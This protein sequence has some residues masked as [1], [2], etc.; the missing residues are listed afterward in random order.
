MARSNQFNTDNHTSAIQPISPHYS[1]ATRFPPAS[2]S[3]ML[4]ALCTALLA[5]QTVQRGA[6]SWEA[7]SQCLCINVQVSSLSLVPQLLPR[8][9]NTQATHL[10][11]F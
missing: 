7:V 9:T 2:A 8:T 5:S 11:M 6:G 10:P 4:S 1:N 3:R